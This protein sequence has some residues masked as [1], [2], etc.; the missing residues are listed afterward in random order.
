MSVIKLSSYSQCVEI[1]DSNNS[2]A[3]TRVWCEH[4]HV[5]VSRTRCEDTV[6]NLRKGERVFSIFSEDY[7]RIR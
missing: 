3:T 6:G 1:P 7:V 5:F 4:R 2:D